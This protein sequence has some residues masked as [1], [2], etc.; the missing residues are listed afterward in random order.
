MISNAYIFYILIFVTQLLLFLR[1]FLF[2]K[3]RM[4]IWGELSK[5]DKKYILL[6]PALEEQWIVHET[7]DY[8]KN[9]FIW[10]EVLFVCIISKNEIIRMGDNIINTTE[11]VIKRYISNDDFLSQHVLILDNPNIFQETKAKKLNFA[12]S[13]LRSKFNLNEY[14]IGVFDFDARIDPQWITYIENNIDIKKSAVVYQYIPLPK[15][16]NEHFFSKLSNFFHLKRV[17][18]F[19]L[20]WIIEYCMGASMFIK[21]S[22]LVTNL[23]PEPIDDIPFWHQIILQWKKKITIPFFTEVSIPVNFKTVFKQMVPVYEGVFSVVWIFI[24]PRNWILKR[25]YFLIIFL[26]IIAEYLLIILSLLLII[27]G[28]IYIVCYWIALWF[29]LILNYNRITNQFLY[30]NITY[31]LLFPLWYFFRALLCIYYIYYKMLN[32]SIYT[33]KT[34]RV[35]QKKWI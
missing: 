26:W 17:F 5:T 23:F 32:K 20:N 13:F 7:L 29:L 31:S 24:N 27:Q 34:S 1:G 30:K 16:Q 14:I 10:K 33:I 18:L 3:R 6:F 12:I 4:G 15:I 28:Y 21:G 22:Y 35:W 8:Y 11:D 19:E 9:I 25:I 2:L